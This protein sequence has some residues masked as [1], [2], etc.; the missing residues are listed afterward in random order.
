M[1]PITIRTWAL[2]LLIVFTSI[3][4]KSVYAD[5]EGTNK[6]GAFLGK[7]SKA[8]S[9]AAE[10]SRQRAATYNYEAASLTG[11]PARYQSPAFSSNPMS[12]MSDA[13]K[14]LM[15]N[16]MWR[17]PKTGLTWMRCILGDKWDGTSCTGNGSN[18][19]FLGDAAALAV[20]KLDFGGHKDWRIPTIAD[21]YGLYDSSGCDTNTEKRVYSIPSNGGHGEISALAT[22]WSSNTTPLNPSIFLVERKPQDQME[23]M[24]ASYSCR[25]PD[26]EPDWAKKESFQSR[27]EIGFSGQG[28]AIY[29][30]YDRNFGPTSYSFR[31]VLMVRGGQSTGEFENI[32]SVAQKNNQA[33]EQKNAEA[34][35]IAQQRMELQ[36][37]RKTAFRKS[38]KPGDNSA[39]GLVIEVRGDAVRVQA[40]ETNCTMRDAHQYGNGTCRQWERQL[41]EKW[42][43]RSSLTP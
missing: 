13:D 3:S 8:L 36:H 37:K 39:Q 10:A 19:D 26:K 42:I 20:S 23:F 25:T 6:V 32:L 7:F 21:L 43:Q 28:R 30:S 33:I 2:T 22:C 35:V 24:S 17:D 41:V 31:Y 16:G 29:C 11:E 14:Q 40:T 4:T 12:N 38:V 27:W 5:V 18:R 9:D 15:A 34:A 1:I